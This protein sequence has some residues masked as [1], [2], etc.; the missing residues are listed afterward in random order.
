MPTLRAAEE[1]G[2]VAEAGAPASGAVE[3]ADELEVDELVW[4]SAGAAA[5]IASA[6]APVSRVE[7]M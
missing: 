1:A 6:A 2:A 7:R 3:G 4:A 5:N